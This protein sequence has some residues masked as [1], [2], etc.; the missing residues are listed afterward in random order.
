MRDSL[1]TPAL[2]VAEEGMGRTSFEAVAI[3]GVSIGDRRHPFEQIL[4]DE[5]TDGE[6]NGERGCGGGGGKSSYCMRVFKYGW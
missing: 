6:T 1:Q 5:R 2:V 4:M 3:C